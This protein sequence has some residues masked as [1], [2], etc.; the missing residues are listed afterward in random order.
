MKN[1]YFIFASIAILLVAW[2]FYSLPKS[3]E[4]EVQGVYFKLMDTEGKETKT[5]N[6]KFEG[7]YTKRLSGGDKFEGII[8][9]EDKK[10]DKVRIDFNKMKHMPIDY[11][12]ESMGEFECFGSIYTN[13]NLDEFTI[14]IYE[15]TDGGGSWNSKD[16]YL[17]SAPCTTREEAIKIYK[18]LS[19]ISY[20]Q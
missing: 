17:I 12:N 6:I 18:K 10:M 3:Y 19:K 1:K 20:N 14:L 8:V 13:G 15:K 16:G 5:V 2:I 9:I 11:I 7:Y 4:R